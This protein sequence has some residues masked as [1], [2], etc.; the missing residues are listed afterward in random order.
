MAAQLLPCRRA[1]IRA[2]L[3]ATQYK[4]VWPLSNKRLTIKERGSGTIEFLLMA[5]T[6][7]LL[8]F[9][10]LDFGR[11]YYAYICLVNAAYAGA[12]YGAMVSGQSS[13]YSAMQTAANND[14]PGTPGF[15]ATASSYCTC[16][17]AGASV[18]CTSS[19]AGYTSPLEY[20]KVQT[21]GSVA[22]FF[23]YPGN[24]G[25][26]ALTTSCTLRVR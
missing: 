25:D 14:D 5:L 17:P 24:T 23:P 12:Q 20:V 3:G 10:L 7:F 8:F 21:S 1:I 9:G 19:C 11:L 2:S 13:N 18:S 4:Q 16:T 6:L 15:G 22:P 26:F